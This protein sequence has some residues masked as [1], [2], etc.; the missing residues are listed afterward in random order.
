MQLLRISKHFKEQNW[1][2]V[3]LELFI[4]FLAV[5]IGLQADNWNQDRIARETAITYYSRLIEDMRAEESSRLAR[6]AY[7]QQALKHG[8]RGLR[9]LKQPDSDLGQQFLI[10]VYQSTQLWNYTPHRAT[11]DELLSIGIANAIPDHETR[12]LLANLYNGLDNSKA[13]QQ[14]ITPL[15]NNLRSH[16]PYGIQREIFKHCGDFVSFLENGVV[17]VKLPEKCD[18]TLDP[19][20][21]FEA[22]TALRSYTDLEKDLTR[23]LSELEGKLLNLN[24]YVQPTRDMAARL[25]ELAN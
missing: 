7:Y 11:Y 14:E 8:E 4:V 1:F 19:K 2:A 10:D 5:F 17:V 15:R 6:I 21:T 24:N 22:V 23:R 20:L 18:L 3:W 12:S 13:I 9:A 25:A 16:M